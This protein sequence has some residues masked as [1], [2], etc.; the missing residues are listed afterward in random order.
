MLAKKEYRI[1]IKPNGLL[2]RLD[3]RKN[4][5]P[6]RHYFTYP[7]VFLIILV[8]KEGFFGRLRLKKVKQYENLC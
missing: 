5:C 2:K 6:A 8:N 3:L 4:Q 1:N 7:V